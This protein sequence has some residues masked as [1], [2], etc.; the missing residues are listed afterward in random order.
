[1]AAALGAAA[2]AAA[3]AAPPLEVYGKLPAVEEI[4]LS[5]SGDRLAVVAVAGENRKLVAAT[6]DGKVL[7]GALIGDT[8]ISSVSWAGDRFL[9]VETSATVDLRLDFNFKYELGAVVV[10]DVDKAKSWGVFMNSR[11]VDHVI[12]GNYGARQA[13]GKWSGYFGGATLVM[14]PQGDVTPSGRA[15]DLYRV[16][17]DSGQMSAVETS[18]WLPR[19]WVMG[20][21]GAVVA[22]SD[23]DQERSRWRLFAGGRKLME[24]I[25]PKHEIEVEGPGRTNGTV[26]VSDDTGD[27][28][29][30]EEVPTAG[31]EPVRLFADVST[32]ELLW[33]PATGLLIGAITRQEPGAMFFDPTL[34]ARYEAARK[35][36]AKFKVSLVSF[37]QGLDRIILKTEGSADPGTYFLVDIAKHSAMPVG[38]DRPEIE[39]ADVAETSLFKYKAS[40]GLEMEGVLTLPPGRDPKN[41]PVVVMPHGGPIGEHDE[42]GFDWWAQAFASRG[43]AVFQPNY[44]G[45][46]GYGVDFRHAGIGEWG[47]KM[48]SDIADGF[49]A[50]A[51]KGIVDPKRACI[52]GASYGG[53]AALSGVT[54]QQ[55]LYRCAVSVA[56]PS[57]LNSLMGWQD[58]KQG[59]GL[60]DVSR[61]WRSW[62]GADKEGSA[63]LSAISPAVFANKADAPVLLVHGKDDTVVPIEQSQRMAAA[64]RAAGKPVEL[65]EISAQDHWLSKAATR[66]AT[67]KASVAFVLA[68]NPPN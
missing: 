61:S 39:D 14:T 40:D 7:D 44:R 51:A 42:V 22:H 6:L 38:Q 16:D 21:D 41:L 65:Q 15:A 49:K 66:T 35:P 55:G 67:V 31:G 24:K 2:P 26:L 37:S 57:D 12:Y 18:D 46:S 52:V 53:Y 5:P 11:T 4:A 17:L 13:G 50:L 45:S 9:L 1:L 36:F 59:G 28:D 34:Q 20:A 30:Y 43:Y 48:L 58:M 56:G 3:F 33:D 47:H 54:L 27:E 8:K 60:N 63:G 32:K 25:S 10:A 19:E 62:M 68:H 23:Y 64:L 29:I